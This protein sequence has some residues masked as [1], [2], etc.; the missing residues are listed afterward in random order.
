MT[1]LR[2]AADYAQ[3]K[4]R[5]LIRP[6]AEPRETVRALRLLEKHEASS[7]EHADE[8]DLVL[9]GRL[10]ALAPAA[11]SPRDLGRVVTP[12]WRRLDRREESAR[13]WVVAITDRALAL[14]RRPTDRAIVRT[15]LDVFPE[16]PAAEHLA[17]AAEAA[18]ER[19]DWAFRPAGRVFDL[20]SPQGAPARIGDALLSSLEPD[21]VLRRAALTPGVYGGRLVQSAIERAAESVAR[22]GQETAARDVAALLDLI[23]KLG[24]AGLSSSLVPL[25]VRA[26]LEPWTRHAA[27]ADLRT[28]AQRFVL[29]H[30]GDPRTAERAW[31]NL[32]AA[33]AERGVA[34]D[35]E[36]LR[37]VV[38]RWLV[39]ANFEIFFR[40]I[41][42]S[43]SNKEQWDAREEFWR[44]YLENDHVDDARF[45]LGSA[46]ERQARV[47]AGVLSDA[48]G[49]GRF[50]YEHDA[51]A[52]AL[53][54]VIGD[55]IVAE[56]THNGSACFWETG[57]V[58]RPSITASR[59]DGR[60][61]RA[62]D[63]MKV[64]ALKQARALGVEP[65]WTAKSHNPPRTRFERGWH[66]KFAR[67]IR[68]LA[69]IRWPEAEW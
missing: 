28:R 2:D 34:A 68:D 47:H 32:E 33:L 52:S 43:T 24:D 35:V 3:S 69:G 21:E 46:A 22:T 41:G 25:L 49:Y 61:M 39:R 17:Q 11:I 45:I 56:W 50:E 55:V 26:I 66:R 44:H 14:E 57:A 60:Y 58:H 67:H 6:P 16:G 13:A 54:M 23:D 53:L 59:Y 7:R 42:A 30:V 19:H 40:I 31:R 29:R 36:A 12:A 51:S 37:D 8:D 18:A 63:V 65:L 20:W 48:G 27:D 9:L 38:R 4:A 5:A 10:R 15:W 64:A 62:S 1:G